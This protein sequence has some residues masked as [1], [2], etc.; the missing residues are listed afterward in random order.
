MMYGSFDDHAQ[1]VW[2]FTR[3]Q[4]PNGTFYGTRGKCRKG[5]EAGAK[6]VAEPKPRKAAAKKP[7]VK[8]AKA[9]KPAK[10]TRPKAKKAAAPKPMKPKAKA[11]LDKATPEQLEKL[12][13]HPKLT[14]EQ[15]KVLDKAISEKKAKPEEGYTP[16]ERGKVEKPN[17]L[18]KLKEKVA[19]KAK[20]D[21][22]T[23]G[24][25]NKDEIN[26]AY[27]DRV[28]SVY[29]H[30]TNIEDGL[31]RVEEA[32]QRAL[33]A[34]DENKKFAKALKEEMPK[35]FRAYVDPEYGFIAMEKKIGKHQVRV[36]YS[37]S[38]GMNY[39]VNGGYAAGTVT[40][41]KEQIRIATSVREAWDAI[42]RASPEG[43]RFTTTAFNGDGKADAREKAYRKI[44]FGEPNEVDEMVAVKRGGKVVPWNDGDPNPPQRVVDFA[45]DDMTSAWMEVIFPGSEEEE[46]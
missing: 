40:D 26:E 34:H 39:K 27:N 14:P 46:E 35:G 32:R 30:A 13:S 2:D 41:R 44:G 8:G 45:E 29:R 17:I 11:A 23:I 43:Q 15:K 25:K 6:E 18:Q 33:K 16:R 3:C 7:A 19:G 1:E 5:D 31:K 21:I 28:Q 24:F 12:K 36:E 42:V 4:R 10:P 20:N 38:T 22:E 9:E 37:P